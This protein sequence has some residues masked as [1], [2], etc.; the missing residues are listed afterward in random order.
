M[1]SKQNFKMYQYG[2]VQNWIFLDC[3]FMRN[4]NFFLVLIQW[5]NMPECQFLI[6]HKFC[7]SLNSNYSIWILKSKEAEKNRRQ[8]QD[9]S[10]SP[11]VPPPPSDTWISFGKLSIFQRCYWNRIIGVLLLFPCY[12]RHIPSWALWGWTFFWESSV[13]TPEHGM[14]PP[15]PRRGGFAWFFACLFVD[16][17]HFC[18]LWGIWVILLIECLEGMEAAVLCRLWGIL[19]AWGPELWSFR[20]FCTVRAANNS[21][22]AVEAAGG[23]WTQNE[24]SHPSRAAAVLAAFI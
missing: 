4:F 9:V 13:P 20:V 22:R 8:E 17:S 3:H 16:L 24:Q 10:K 5:K 11:F 6:W 23:S 21:S 2:C 18:C 14:Q 19:L 15:L 1:F 7:F 12:C